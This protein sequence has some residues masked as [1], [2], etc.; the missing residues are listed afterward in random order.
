VA[1]KI[2]A[3]NPDSETLANTMIGPITP[4]PIVEFR[5]PSEPDLAPLYMALAKAQGAFPEIPKNRT[6]KVR[7]KSGGEFSFKYSDLADLINATRKAL[8]ESGLGQFQ[9]PSKDKQECITI[10]TH[11]SGVSI[12]GRYPVHPSGEGRMHPAQ[13]WAIAFAYA[14]RYGLSAMLGVA[15]EETVQ[16]DDKDK[17]GGIDKNFEGPDGVV[18]VRGAKPPKSSKPEDRAKSAADAI[19]AQLGDAK[20]KVG[21]DGVWSRNQAVI[22][23]LQDSYA[24]LYDDL[25]SIYEKYSAGFEEDAS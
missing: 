9:H 2:T 6:A 13:D 23:R 11:D 4:K 25:I 22:D 17:G 8:S 15:A 20:T 16:G 24:S 5:L 14:R 21:L 12:E 10:L 1:E 7:M 3:S 19:E 18:T